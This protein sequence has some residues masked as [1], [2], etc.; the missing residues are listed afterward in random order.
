MKKL[1]ILTL[2]LATAAFAQTR[3][4]PGRGIPPYRLTKGARLN[5]IVW[6][7]PTPAADAQYIAKDNVGTLRFTIG[8][9]PVAGYISDVYM[10]SGGGQGADSFKIADT[11]TAK[12][13]RIT[14]TKTGGDTL[15]TR[16]TVGPL[17]A[18]KPL[19]KTRWFITG[20]D[21]TSKFRV[22]ADSYLYARID[23]VGAQGD[24]IGKNFKFIYF[25]FADDLY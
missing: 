13:Y 23:T 16:T 3:S 6:T 8:Y 9:F 22:S 10:I 14:I 24:S 5:P 7:V 11:A 2:A 17:A 20:T 15:G 1:I 19:P 25:F 21:T 12:A 4:Y 18:N